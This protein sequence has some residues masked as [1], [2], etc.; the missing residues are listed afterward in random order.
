MT[1]KETG[2]KWNKIKVGGIDKEKERKLGTFIKLRI[3]ESLKYAFFF[4]VMYRVLQDVDDYVPPCT[5]SNSRNMLC[6]VFL[7]PSCVQYVL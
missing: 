7:G 3:K 4:F 1:E 6:I 2:K 5:Y